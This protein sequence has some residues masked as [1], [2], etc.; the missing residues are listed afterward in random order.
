MIKGF[1]F[2]E[3][4]EVMNFRKYLGNNLVDVL[5]LDNHS[6]H[7]PWLHSISLNV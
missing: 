3:M 6:F 4:E 2:F 1:Y 7:D 5:L